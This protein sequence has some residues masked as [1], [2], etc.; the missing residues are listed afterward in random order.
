L[1]HFACLC[2]LLSLCVAAGAQNVVPNPSFEE[3]GG[4][5]TPSNHFPERAT[6]DRTTAVDGAASLKLDGGGGE[7]F[8]D[9]HCQKRLDLQPGRTYAVQVAIRRTTNKGTVGLAVMEKPDQPAWRATHWFGDK[10]V[11]GTDRWQVFQGRFTLPDDTQSTALI[12]Y[13]INSGGVAWYDDI[14]LTPVPGQDAPWLLRCRRVTAPPTLD[15][16]LDEWQG[17]DRAVD[18]M[19]AGTAAVCP[20]KSPY[21]AEVSLAY[22][23]TNLYVAAALHEPPGHPRQTATQGLDSAVW[24]DDDLEV[25][26]APVAGRNDFCQFAINSAGALYDAYQPPDRPGGGDPSWN[27]GATV[28]TAPAADGWT[29]EMAIPL[30][31]L[32]GI[33]P[34]AGS[35]AASFCRNLPAVKQLASWPRLQPGDGFATTTNFQTVVCGGAPDETPRAVSLYRTA[36]VEG[37]LVNADFAQTDEQGRPRFWTPEAGKLTQ[38]LQTGPYNAGA[39]LS[40]VVLPAGA[41]ATSAELAYQTAA[42]QELIEKAKLDGGPGGW[43]TAGFTLREGAQTLTRF[44][45]AWAGGPLPAVAQLQTSGTRTFHWLQKQLFDFQMNGNLNV[46]PKDQAATYVLYPEVSL[47]R[48]QPSPVSLN[49]LQTFGE[50]TG[51]TMAFR[52]PERNYQLVLDLPAGVELYS[53]GLMSRFFTRDA[54]GPQESPYGKDYRRTVVPLVRLSPCIQAC[55]YLQTTLPAGEA[56]PLYYHLTWDGGTQP[57][58]KLPVTIYEKPDVKAPRRFVASVYYW[59]WDEPSSPRSGTIFDDPRAAEFFAGLHGMGLNT[60]MINSLW[61]RDYYELPRLDQL[62]PLITKAGFTLAHHTGG[63]GYQTALARK[64]GAMAVTLDG[65]E[66]AGVCLS[67]RGAGYQTCVKTWG[68]LALH[69]IYWVDND[70]EDF[71]YREDQVCFCPHCKDGFRAWLAA[72]QPTLAYQDPQEF[73]R[74]P[75]DFTDLHRAW[76]RYKNSLLAGWHDDVRAAMLKHMQAAGVTAP[77]FPKIGVTESMTQWDWQTLTGGP[78]DYISPMVYAYLQGYT[79]PAVEAMGKTCLRDRERTGVD[80]GKYIVTIA[81]AER[82]GEAVWPDK[83]MMYQVLEVAGSGAAGFKI[84]YEEVMNGGQYYWMSRALRMIQPVEDI[85]LDGQFVKVPAET[86]N[87]RVHAFRHPTG[88]VLFVADYSV[89]KVE[90]ALSE[91][92]AAPAVVMDLDRGEQLASLKPGATAFQLTIDEDRVRLLFVGTQAQWR[93]VAASR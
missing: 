54:I 70:Y 67:Y 10:G 13:N 82:T 91:P 46:L 48:N 9:S 35:L 76:W 56:K 21:Q 23:D 69:G 24:G 15:G 64:D 6:L 60:F 47:I 72:N 28:K 3:P 40:L 74:R 17:A 1:R 44:S 7:F 86:P 66:D 78:L 73:E 37:L 87:T 88:T 84:W 34:D 51:T 12:L 25:L 5:G 65:K 19:V 38:A 71:N 33:N 29:V 41:K 92:V 11:R 52:G 55:L 85:L 61:G 4:W 22:D 63:M 16:K 77:G 53:T 45:L 26:L 39:R 50:T 14:S 18:F 62:L 80:R 27:S 79:E 30:K 81:P 8:V 42:G 57:D 43:Q 93:K 58:E 89:D 68:D 75:G 49:S 90:L 32:P 36:R 31:N 59:F 2:A 83:S 20:A